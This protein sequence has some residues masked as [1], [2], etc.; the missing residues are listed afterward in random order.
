[1]ISKECFTKKWICDRS[2]YL[3]SGKKKADPELIEKVMI[4]RKLITSFI[5]NLF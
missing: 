1:M 4:F 2:N 3:K 5:I